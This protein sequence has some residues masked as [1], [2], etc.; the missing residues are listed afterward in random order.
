MQKQSLTTSHRHGHLGSQH[1]PSPLLPLP[2]FLSQHATLHGTEYPFGRFGSVLPS[3]SP[4]NALSA[5]S[6]LAGE[7]GGVGKEKALTLAALSSNSKNISV[8]ST[9]F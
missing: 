5:P 1:S 8:L 3:A 9:L 6:L 7:A 2:W 4:L